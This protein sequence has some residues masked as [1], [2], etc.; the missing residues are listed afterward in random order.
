MRVVQAWGVNNHVVSI[1]LH[2]G[3]ALKWIWTKKETCTTFLQL[4][5]WN[6]AISS[7]NWMGDHRKEKIVREA[8][9]KCMEGLGRNCPKPSGDTTSPPPLLLTQQ[10]GDLPLVSHAT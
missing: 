3:V 2:L 9:W 10:Q 5:P 8:T 1:L 7:E 4:P 6:V